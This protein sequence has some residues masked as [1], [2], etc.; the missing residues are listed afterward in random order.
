MQYI[1]SEEEWDKHIEKVR[2]LELLPSVEELQKFCTFVS[3]NVVLTEGWRAGHVWGC[4][5]SS[6]REWYCDDCPATKV[7][8]YP[9]KHWS[10]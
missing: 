10:K 8:P 4:I 5:L 3:D 6:D 1:L 9:N 7:C 2:V